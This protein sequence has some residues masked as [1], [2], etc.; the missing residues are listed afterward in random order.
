MTRRWALG[1]GPGAHVAVAHDLMVPSTLLSLVSA[2]LPVMLVLSIVVLPN[3]AIPPPT[4]T[5][6]VSV[7]P[8]WPARTV[9]LAPEGEPPSPMPTLLACPGEP[10]P[11]AKAWFVV[12]SSV[13]LACFEPF[14]APSSG[15]IVN[16]PES[17]TRMPPPKPMPLSPPS[18]PS[19]PSVSAAIAAGPD[20]A[21]VAAVAARGG[22]AAAAVTAEAAANLVTGEID[23]HPGEGCGSCVVQ[24]AAGAFIGRAARAARAGV[25]EPS[26]AAG[27]ATSPPLPA[28]PLP[29]WPPPPPPPPRA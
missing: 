10:A 22:K 6:S 19:P 12:I 13:A 15:L 16:V 4:P 18:P 17:S 20:V 29:A 11:D 7:V 1:N 2:R 9:P 24:S 26:V 5:V 28:N 8:F 3:V 23:G 27:P 21:A 25:R 14:F